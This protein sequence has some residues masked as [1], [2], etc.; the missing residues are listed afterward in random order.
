L[1]ALPPALVCIPYIFSM[2]DRFPVHLKGSRYAGPAGAAENEFCRRHKLDILS[3]GECSCDPLHDVA[4]LFR[5][6]EVQRVAVM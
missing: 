1:K 4:Q 6:G 3:R 2:V 5:Y